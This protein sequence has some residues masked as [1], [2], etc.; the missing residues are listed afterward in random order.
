MTPPHSSSSSGNKSFAAY[1]VMYALALSSLVLDIQRG[2]VLFTL[3]GIVSSILLTAL[4]AYR[5]A[6]AMAVS[7]TGSRMTPMPVAEPSP[8]A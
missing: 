7:P 4:I 5:M 1:V 3:V 8:V 2:G 6:Q